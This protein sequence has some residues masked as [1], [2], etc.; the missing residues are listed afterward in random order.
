[1]QKKILLIDDDAG[2]HL[3]TVP[4]L[5]KAGY[6]VVSA[7]SGE[8]GIQVALDQRPDLILLDVIMP[9]IK[10]RD[11]CVKLKSYAVLKDIPVV[12][13]TALDSD[14]TIEAELKLGAVAHLTKPVDP[15]QLT[16]TIKAIIG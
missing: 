10:G 11:L 12:F 6:L 3:L 7:K 4:I 2:V 9:G 14:D 15:L 8:Q 16:Q 5:T 1:M 13:F